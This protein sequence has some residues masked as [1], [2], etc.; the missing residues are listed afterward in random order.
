MIKK[1]ILSTVCAFAMGISCFAGMQ[2]AFSSD[3]VGIT[4]SA[5]TATV[6]LPIKRIS[7]SNRFETAAEE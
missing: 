7:G 1:R 2:G 5:A 6:N 3:E 4:A